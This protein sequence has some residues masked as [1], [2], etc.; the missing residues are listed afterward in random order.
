MFRDWITQALSQPL[1][2]RVCIDS[3]IQ[4][5]PLD[6]DASFRRYTR[7]HCD[8]RT[9]MAVDA[10]PQT[11]DNAAFVSI[12]QQWSQAGI[13]VPNIL[14]FDLDYGFMLQEDFGDTLLSDVLARDAQTHMLS[15]LNVVAAS[16]GRYEQALATQARISQIHVADL[17]AFD[18]SLLHQEMTLFTDWLCQSLLGLTLDEHEQRAFKTLFHALAERALGQPQVVVHR[19]YHA[20]NLMLLADG[21]VGVID[22]QDAVIGPYTYDAV[23]LL[24][25]CYTRLPDD[26]FESLLT[27]FATHCAQQPSASQLRVDF[28][29]M[30]LQRHLKAAGI[31]ARLWLRDGKS[32][33]LTDIPNTV[34]YLV[35]VSAHYPDFDWFSSWLHTRF[36]PAWQHWQQQPECPVNIDTKGAL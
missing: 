26:V 12:A 31:F 11:E 13:R 19:D 21:D 34:R 18:A 29:W 5:Y 8:G 3:A 4:F 35:D 15:P 27:T 2:E 24:R 28:D 30:G 16:Q 7:I 22:F 25:D 1:S 10:P 14:A 33:Y 6:G 32:G 23:S 17:P 36:L 20:R 9:W